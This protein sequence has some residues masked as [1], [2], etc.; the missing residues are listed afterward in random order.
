MNQHTLIEQLELEWELDTGFFGRL[1]YG[2]FDVAGLERIVYVLEGIT[3]EVKDYD[4][5]NRRL[6]ALLWFIPTFMRWQRERVQKQ[7]GN[8]DALDDGIDAIEA[9]LQAILGVP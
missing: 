2:N 1:R 6:V 7:G 5:L 9:R 8:L 4:V 3:E